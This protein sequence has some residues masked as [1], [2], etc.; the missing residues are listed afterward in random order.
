MVVHRRRGRHAVQPRP[1]V[2]G[3]AQARIGP[4]G[5]QQRVLQD[6]LRV[7]VT[8][9]PAGVHEQLVAVGFYECPERWQHVR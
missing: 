6:V 8:R 5:A 2:L 9:Q 4:Q 3:V 1:Q 7:L